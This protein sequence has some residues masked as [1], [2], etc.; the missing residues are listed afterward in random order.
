MEANTL[1]LVWATDDNYVF[2]TGVSMSSAFENN[3]DFEQIRVWT[4]QIYAGSWNNTS[5]EGAAKP[6]LPLNPPS[7]Q[8]YLL[9]QEPRFP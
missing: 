8:I 2:L 7:P 9:H 4:P 1:D 5:E 6:Q 3:K